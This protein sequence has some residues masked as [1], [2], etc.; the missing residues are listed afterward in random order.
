VTLSYKQ[1]A[2]LRFVRLSKLKVNDVPGISGVYVVCWI[3]GGS[4]VLISRVLGVD[5]TGI[6]YVGSKG[7][8]KSRLGALKKY[9]LEVIHLAKSEELRYKEFKYVPPPTQV[10]TKSFPRRSSRPIR[11]SIVKVKLSF[12]KL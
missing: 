6:L 7:N 1:E 4:K 12:R 10:L 11:F 5:R 9:A 2:R 8:L 3:R